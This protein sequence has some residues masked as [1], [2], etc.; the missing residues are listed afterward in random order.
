VTAPSRERPA[1]HWAAGAFVVAA[2]AGVGLVL[3]F[4][5]GGQTQ[6]EGVLGGVA[7][8]GIGIGLVIW[9]NGLLDEGPVEQERERLTATPEEAA[10]L[11]IDIERGAQIGRRKLLKRTLLAAGTALGAGLLVPLGSLGPDPDKKL[12]HTAWASGVRVVT[13]DGD[14]VSAAALPLD[15]LLTVF[16]EGD[17]GSA[18]GQ[19]VLVRVDPQLLQLPASRATWA[20]LGI[21]AYSKVCTHAGCPVGLYVA[22]RHELLCPCHQ[23]SFDV[24]NG[25]TPQ[26]GPAAWPLPQ[27][28]LVVDSDGNLRASGPLSAPVGPGWWSA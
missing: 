16:P 22:D 8:L 15:G 19:V 14:P 27:L 24:L 18:D 1:E 2:L 25:A 17:T 10:A 13:D 20:P 28:P 6:L 26:S 7:F 21:V 11:R 12:L 23:S 9:A 4:V 3:V 5:F